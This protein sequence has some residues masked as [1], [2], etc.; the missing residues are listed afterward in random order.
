MS[1]YVVRL[2]PKLLMSTDSNNLPCRFVGDHSIIPAKKYYS[3]GYLILYPESIGHVHISSAEDVN[4]P[5][6]F[7]PMY[8]TKSARASSFPRP[9]VL[10]AP[11]GARTLLFCAG[12]TSSRGRLHEGWHAIVASASRGTL[13]SPRAAAQPAKR[14]QSLWICMRPTYSTRK[15]TIRP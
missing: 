10:T 14:T 9:C 4:A 11:L 2:V 5:Q 13:F 12:P 15:K 1:L 3:M 8:I 7:D 6:D